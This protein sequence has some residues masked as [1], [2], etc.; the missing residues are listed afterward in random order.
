MDEKTAKKGYLY[1]PFCQQIL[2]QSKTFSQKVIHSTQRMIKKLLS[3][4][5]LVHT[6]I[7]PIF[8]FKTA[9]ERIVLP[10]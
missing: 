1:V 7:L 10:V 4:K 8:T 5:K 3:Q 9:S 2:I 6:A